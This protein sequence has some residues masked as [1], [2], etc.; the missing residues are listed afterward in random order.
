MKIEGLAAQ[1]RNAHATPRETTSREDTPRTDGAGRGATPPSVIV[2]ITDAA[3]QP[4]GAPGKSAESP[5][6]RAR[7]MI[8][9][10]VAMGAETG[11]LHF[12]QVVSRIARGLD[13][14]ELF[15]LPAPPAEEE[16]TEPAGPLV[17]GEG[18]GATSALVETPLASPE[19]EIDPDLVVASLLLEETVEESDTPTTLVEPLAAPEPEIDPELAVASLL[20]EETADESS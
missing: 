2:D 5:A 12:G 8:E 9:S 15:V 18:E 16:P 1:V 13:A 6:H 19:P 20:L 7:A 11:G 3:D 10:Y 14:S 17:E 4:L